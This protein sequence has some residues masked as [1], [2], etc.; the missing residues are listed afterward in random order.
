MKQGMEKTYHH[1]DLK[2]ALM[3][4]ALRMIAAHEEHQIGFRELAR[5][6]DVSRSA[7][8]R[9]FESVEH[10]FASVI[11]QGYHMFIERLQKVVNAQEWDARTRFLELG[12]TYITF[13][14]EHPAHYRLMFDQRF[15]RGSPYPEIKKLSREAFRLLKHTVQASLPGDTP[16]HKVNELSQLAWACVHGMSRLF[17]D[18]QWEG[19][20]H[21]QEFIRTSCQRLL[22]LVDSV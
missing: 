9:H 5:R 20:R 22:T 4:T 3:N 11:E 21:R 14:L 6:L 8:Y 18:G 10:L 1:G 19:L 15:F 7:P 13:A 16:G 2:A 12:I 17:I